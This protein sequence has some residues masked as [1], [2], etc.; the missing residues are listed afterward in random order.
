M[1]FKEKHPFISYCIVRTHILLGIVYIVVGLKP[2]FKSQICVVLVLL[3][4]VIV[5]KFLWKKLYKDE[6]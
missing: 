5:S 6:G 3:L 4:C 2:T 1:R